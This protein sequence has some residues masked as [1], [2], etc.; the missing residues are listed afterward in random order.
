MGSNP[1]GSA[2][3]NEVTPVSWT[4]ML[5]F[6]GVLFIVVTVIV[7][8]HFIVQKRVI[9]LICKYKLWDRFLAAVSVILLQIIVYISYYWDFTIRTGNTE[10]FINAVVFWLALVLIYLVG[11][12]IYRHEHPWEIP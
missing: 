10:I 5:Q 1:T 7:I 6:T 11:T 9:P 12:G 3:F 2:R 4:V 8:L